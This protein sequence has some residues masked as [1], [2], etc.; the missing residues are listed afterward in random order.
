MKTSQIFPSKYLAAAD[1]GDDNVTF[2]IS[3]ASMEVLNEE[4]KLIL[5]FHEVKKGMVLNKTNCKALEAALGSDD[6]DDWIGRQI[7]LF[8]AQVDFQG[9]TVDAIRVHERKT[10]ALAKQPARDVTPPAP[11]ARRPAITQPQR[12]QPRDG[13]EPGDDDEDIAF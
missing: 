10:K 8:S 9:R 11:P 13:R 4:Q 12:Q 7:V 1:L 3:D 5:Y 6:T 2:T